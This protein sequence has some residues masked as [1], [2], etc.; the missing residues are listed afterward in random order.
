MDSYGIWVF[1]HILLLVYWLGADLGVF[2]LARGAK[3]TGYT[4]DQRAVMLKFALYIDVTPRAAF[5][6]MFPVGLHMS[7]QIGLVDVAPWV[8]LVT[9]I[10]AALWLAAIM[11]VFLRGGKPIATRLAHILLYW[12]GVLLVVMVGIGCYSLVTGWPFVTAWLSVK[13]I[14]FGLIAACGIGIDWFFAP[15]VPAFTRLATEGSSPELEQIIGQTINRTCFIVLVL[16]A[17]LLILAFLG[18]TQPF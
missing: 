13:I 7:A 3:N 9:W 4:F 18:I 14:L 11:T 8:F 17:L 16:Y 6:L 10:A 1:A 15:I 2:L 5:A 12:Q